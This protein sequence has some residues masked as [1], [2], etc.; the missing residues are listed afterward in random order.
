MSD[1]FIGYARE[2]RD[3]AERVAAALASRD[4]TVFWDKLIP[5]GEDYTE[6]LE[7]E[8]AKA[9]CVAVLW[10]RNSIKKTFV[11]EEAGRA[12]KNETYLPVLL[13]EVQL[14]MGF[15][16][17]QWENLSAWDGDS[18]HPAC[19][20]LISRISKMVEA[21]RPPIA[22][23]KPLPGQHITDEH[24]VLVHSSK[25][26]DDQDEK[27]GARMYQIYV[28]VFCHESVL[29]QIEQVEYFLD[30]SYPKNYYV[31]TDRGKN[32]RL[33]ELANGY[34]VVRAKV[35]ISGQRR[36]VELSRFINLTRDATDLSRF[37]GG[38]RD[39]ESGAD[40]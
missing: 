6:V 32:F 1:V 9:K 30:P 18:S 28:I 5:G 8:V 10:S 17:T 11:R 16:A 24:I 37:F 33:K 4:I 34:S 36:K 38:W 15:G 12:V 40:K 27:H 26:R 20:E 29:E 19:V 35:R 3:K 25:R 23:P 13:E 14:P 22:V 31:E 2:D 21:P 39:D 7:E